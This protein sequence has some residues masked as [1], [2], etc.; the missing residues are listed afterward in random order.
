MNAA[1][2]PI[3]TAEQR[4][5]LLDLPA[6]LV[7]L[8]EQI[9]AVADELGNAELLVARRGTDVRL[10]ANFTVQVALGSLYEAAVDVIQQKADAALKTGATQQ[11]RNE[12]LRK[13]KREQLK[14]KLDTYLRHAGRYNTRY[15]PAQ[16]L[17]EPTLDE[18]IA[19]DLLDPF[20]DEVALNHLDEPWASCQSTKDGIIAL[21]NHMASEEE[22]RRLGREVRQLMGWALD[23]QVRVDRS[24]PNEAIGRQHLSLELRQPLSSNEIGVFFIFDAG[25]V[26]MAEWK[27]V[28]SG[29]AKRTY[30]LWSF[31]DLGL[32]EVVQ[33]TGDY[34]EGTPEDDNLLL[35]GWQQMR[36]RTLGTAICWSKL[37]LSRTCRDV[38]SQSTFSRSRRLY[39]FKIFMMC[40]NSELTEYVSKAY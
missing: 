26:R 30:R 29:I 31:W 37:S 24:K 16:R 8:E 27:S 40:F 3:R 13:K 14:N 11:P 10:K 32:Q 5:E 23:Y 18:V 20:W 2:A 15:R 12:Q 34:V 1:N 36:A 25:G 9:Q 33:S 4:H 6:S 39:V 7:A 22:L 21:R 17:A 19:M 38:Y 28:H 35:L